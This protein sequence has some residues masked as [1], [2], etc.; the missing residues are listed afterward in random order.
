MWGR[1]YSKSEAAA[2]PKVMR[3]AAF[4]A[5]ASAPA[6]ANRGQDALRTG[7]PLGGKAGFLRTAKSG[8]SA[9]QPF[10]DWSTDPDCRRLVS[11]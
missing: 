5:P 8:K 1:V 3:G 4:F 2:N 6:T 7:C 11:L 10:W 9:G